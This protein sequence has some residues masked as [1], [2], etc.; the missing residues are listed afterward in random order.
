MADVA[1]YWNSL[2]SSQSAPW[3]IGEPQPE[4]VALERAGGIKGAVLDIGCGTGEHVIHL[5]GLGYDAHG[6]DVS[7]LAI[8]TARRKARDIGVSPARFTIGDALRLG[9]STYDTILDSAL[10]HVFDAD[11]RA[12]YVHS[13]HTGCKPGGLIHI[14]S[15]GPHVSDLI[16]RDAFGAEWD[17]E[18]LRRARYRGRITE[19]IADQARAKGW[20]VQGLVDV[21]AWLARIRRL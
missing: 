18:E 1:D 15:F 11:H 7:P 13:L 10:F 16:I 17:L 9:G 2:Y 19:S 21:G 14:L 3:V 12:A 8:D 5:A 4:I 6:I 20:P